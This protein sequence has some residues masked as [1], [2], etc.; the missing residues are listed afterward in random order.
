MG[1]GSKLG[2]GAGHA[3]AQLHGKQICPALT[4]FEV[5]TCHCKFKCSQSTELTWP[6]AAAAAAG[7]EGGLA[8]AGG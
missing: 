2:T 8:C 1:A 3:R 4:Q 7:G 6:G 5:R